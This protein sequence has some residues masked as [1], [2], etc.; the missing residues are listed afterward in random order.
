VII[1]VFAPHALGMK[2]LE[3]PAKHSQAFSG[4]NIN[5]STINKE[6]FTAFY[7]R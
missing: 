1:D 4:F 5:L 2:N 7:G 3:L 6:S